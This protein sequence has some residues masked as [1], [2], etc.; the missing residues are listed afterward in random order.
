MSI[1]IVGFCIVGLAV[2]RMVNRILRLVPPDPLCND[3]VPC[4]M[5]QLEPFQALP[6][7]VRET[8]SFRTIMPA[9]GIEPASLQCEAVTRYT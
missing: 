1:E 9:V 3:T 7:T 5:E 4:G 6:S 8:T 2:W